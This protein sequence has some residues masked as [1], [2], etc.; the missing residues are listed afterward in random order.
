M[1]FYPFLQIATLVQDLRKELD[2]LL[3]NKI[4]N[5][6]LDLCRARESRIID[7]IVLLIQL[8]NSKGCNAIYNMVII[9]LFLSPERNLRVQTSKLSCDPNNE[10][11]LKVIPSIIISLTSNLSL[12]SKIPKT[13]RCVLK[14][15]FV[16]TCAPL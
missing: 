3:E 11:F 13:D 6:S 15:H 10:I 7:T 9:S 1:P 16:H 14:T 12:F 8:N 2:R 4:E 5:P